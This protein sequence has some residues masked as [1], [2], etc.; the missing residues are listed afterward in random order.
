MLEG[1]NLDE[2]VFEVGVDS[3]LEVNLIKVLGETTTNKL[4]VMIDRYQNL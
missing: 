4:Q 3:V 2:E 1:I